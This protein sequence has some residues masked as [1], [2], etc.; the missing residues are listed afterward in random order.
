M[1][2]LAGD[3]LNWIAAGVMFPLMLLP[4]AKV[5]ARGRAFTVAWLAA[6]G[7]VAGAGVLFA[8]LTPVLRR[9]P[10]V[11]SAMIFAGVTLLAAAAVVLT[12]GPER[13]LPR[14]A[15]LFER[16]TRG[17]GRGV[18]WLLLAMAFLQFAIV[19]CRYVF[20]LNSIF[21]QESI[22]YMHG[23]VFLLAGGYALLTDD[24]VRVDIFYREAP[25]RT[26]ALIDFL[27]FY[28]LLLPVCLLMLWTAAPYVASS[29]RVGEGS[30]E[31]SGIPVLY[32]LKSFIPAFAVLMSLA[33]FVIAERASRVL[34]ERG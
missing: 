20:G 34:T 31:A 22:T 18:M 3:I 7:L 5:A 2:Q 28:L 29:W 25:P 6:I 27:G 19:I 13:V 33:G 10:T 21:V 30:A 24:H 15:N 8:M 4:L 16:V 1:L 12:G 17:I 23:A 9:A 11:E 32:I 14:L 26:R